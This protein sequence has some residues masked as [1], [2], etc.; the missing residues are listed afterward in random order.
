MLP[1]E[2]WTAFYGDHLRL[3]GT[4]IESAEPPDDLAQERV[5]DVEIRALEKVAKA[6]TDLPPDQ[7]KAIHL[8]LGPRPGKLKEM[9]RE[10]GV[11]YSILR[12]RMIAGLER[13]RTKIKTKGLYRP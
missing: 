6:L 10:I 3:F 5:Y 9:C 4:E 2:R 11:P 7:R 8:I 12:S 13:I 1:S